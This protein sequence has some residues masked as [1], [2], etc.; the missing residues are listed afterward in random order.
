MRRPSNASSSVTGPFLPISRVVSPTSTIGSPRRAAAIPSPSRVCAFSRTR[1]AATSASKALRS[2]ADGAAGCSVIGLLLCHARLGRE[3][4]LI[5]G[6]EAAPAVPERRR[7]LAA[8][9]GG[10]H[11]EVH[12]PAGADFEHGPPIGQ[13]A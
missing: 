11:V 7:L 9:A 3:S 12:V 1:R 2:T 5:F 8:G 6:L 4:P 10:E 13:A